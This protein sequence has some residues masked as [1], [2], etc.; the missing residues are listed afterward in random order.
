MQC[1]I[2]CLQMV[3]EHFGKRYSAYE[4]AHH[5]H[6]TSEGVS[7][8]AIH[9]AALQLGFQATGRMTSINQLYHCTLP[10]ILHWNQNHFVVLYKINARHKHLYIAD[11][12][13]GLR[14]CLNFAQFHEALRAFC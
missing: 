4:M 12:S 13:K 10:C 14:A 8:H 9:E 7:L 6:A 11:P 2:A 3:C 1:G 5:C